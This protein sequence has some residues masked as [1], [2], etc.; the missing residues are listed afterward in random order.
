[1]KTLLILLSSAV[2]AS[3]TPPKNSHDLEIRKIWA[4]SYERMGYQF[5]PSTTTVEE[6][7]RR[8]NRQKLEKDLRSVREENTAKMKEF[9]A[10]PKSPDE[11][12]QFFQKMGNQRTKVFVGKVSSY[13]PV[14]MKILEDYVAEILPKISLNG[15]GM[16]EV[17]SGGKSVTMLPIA[18]VFLAFKDEDLPEMHGAIGYVTPNGKDYAGV[19]IIPKGLGYDA[20]IPG[21]R[22]RVVC[23]EG[24]LGLAM[25]EAFIPLVSL[26][27]DV[28]DGP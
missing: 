28:Q 7:E 24:Q 23:K 22:A 25:P 19:M 27:F 11:I 16:V 14:A 3:A 18:T 17:G 6:M 4:A 21:G 12:R 2:L 8:Y 15:N 1:M 20:I 9:E 13:T 10:Q 5:D 26:Q